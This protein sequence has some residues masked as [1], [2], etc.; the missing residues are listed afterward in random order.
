MQLAQSQ[1]PSAP[2]PEVE[3]ASKEAWA[4]VVITNWAEGELA[5][6]YAVRST[7]LARAWSHVSQTQRRQLA[8]GFDA[9]PEASRGNVAAFAA[10]LG[11]TDPAA[12]DL[13]SAWAI[14]EIRLAARN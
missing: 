8:T 7:A 12:L 13:L 14:A 5:A 11:L 10:E 3:A 2:T 1:C 6:R 9:A 4:G